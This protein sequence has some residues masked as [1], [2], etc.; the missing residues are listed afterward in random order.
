MGQ[1]D[2]PAHHARG[3]MNICTNGRFVKG[4]ERLFRQ[5]KSA[6]SGAMLKEPS[7]MLLHSR[8]ILAMAS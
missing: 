4:A 8:R 2:R 7:R 5:S 6:R 3:R 1:K